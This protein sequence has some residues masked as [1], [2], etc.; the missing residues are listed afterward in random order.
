[1]WILGILTILALAGPQTRPASITSA[2]RDDPSDPNV[3]RIDAIPGITEPSDLLLRGGSLFTV[4]DS[5][6][7]VYR[8]AFDGPGGAPRRAGTWTP[9]GLPD[10]VDLEAL[11]ELPTGEV[12]LASENTGSIFVLSPFPE[13]ACAAWTSGIPGS[14]FIGRPNCGIEAMAVLPGGRL[15]AAKERDPRGAWLFDLPAK[16]CTA[17]VLSGRTYLKLPDEVGPDI[18][19]ATYHAGTGHLLLVARSRQR[20]LELEVPEPTPGDTSPRALALVGSFSYASAENVLDYEGIDFH[21][22][23]GI[24]VDDRNVLYLCVDNNDRFSRAFG[25][26]RPALIRFFPVR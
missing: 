25:N 8:L 11:A 12:L 17:A 14:C 18:A 13:H 16:P 26:A 5:H 3:T 19:A 23:E 24:A 6:R 10:A 2:W 15:F 21:Q 4:S 7:S 20:V 22:V 1:M 9:S